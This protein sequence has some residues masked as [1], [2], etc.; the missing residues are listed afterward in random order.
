LGD[1]TLMLHYVL[2]SD[3]VEVVMHSDDAFAP[4]AFL[5]LKKLHLEEKAHDLVSLM[6]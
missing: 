1:V 3:E 5:N 6:V 2:H 4:V